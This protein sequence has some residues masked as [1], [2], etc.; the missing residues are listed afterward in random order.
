MPTENEKKYVL[1]PSFNAEGL[2]GWSVERIEQ[3]YLAQKGDLFCKDDGCYFGCHYFVK[4]ANRFVNIEFPIEPRD[5]YDLKEECGGTQLKSGGRIRRS[6]GHYYFTTKQWAEA[7]NRFVE[8]ESFI[9]LRDYEDLRT[10]CPKMLSKARYNKTVGD[11]KWV[12]DFLKTKSGQ[13][14]FV[15]S[16]V[17]MPEGVED[18]KEIFPEIKDS[19]I[20]H[21]E[22]N[23]ERFTNKELINQE[24]AKQ[25]YKMMGVEI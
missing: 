9:D 21:V 14:Y 7:A 23:D 10:E 1:S 12:V 15:M 13:V 24:H 22:K 11:E 6:D 2:A 19:I 5:F 3:G 25:M 17:E 16:E 8:I 18:P 4:S 20:W